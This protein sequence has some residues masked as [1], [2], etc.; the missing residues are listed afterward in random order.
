[1]NVLK[2]VIKKT[3]FVLPIT[4][5]YLRSWTKSPTRTWRRLLCPREA[6]VDLQR[7]QSPLKRTVLFSPK[8]AEVGLQQRPEDRKR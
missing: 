8:K 4:I 5:M 2:L 6:V 1:M 3:V 7:P